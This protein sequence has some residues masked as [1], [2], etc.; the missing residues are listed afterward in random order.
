MFDVN[1]TDCNR[2]RVDMS[3]IFHFIKIPS[4]S[5]TGMVNLL[6]FVR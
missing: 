2:D 4:R 1:V 3:E 6:L 5:L